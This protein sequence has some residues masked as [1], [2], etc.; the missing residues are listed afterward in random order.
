MAAMH[1]ATLISIVAAARAR[2]PDIVFILADD[3]GYNEMGFMNSTRGLI[4]PH[5]DGLAAGGIVLRN[6]YVQPICSPT[7]SALMTGRYTVRLGTQSSVIYWDTP[8]GIAL[9]ETF[10]PQN[11]KDAGYI[12]GMFGKWHLGMYTEAYTPA[13]RGFDEHMGYY[14][15]CESH[16]T[17]VAA[18]CGAGSPDHDQNYTCRSNAY[19]GYD[20]FKTGPMPNSGTSKPDLSVNHTNSAYLIRDAAVDF[21]HRAAKQEKP[22]FLYLPFQ[23][24]HGPYTC[25]KKYRDQYTSQGAKFTDGE[26]TMFGYITEMDTAVGTVIAALK[27]SGRYENSIIIFSSDNGAPPA[28]ADVN[29]QHGANPGWIARNYPFRGHK[30][31]IWEGGTRVAG[32]VHSPL[33][34]AKVQGTE[35]HEMFHI[36]D[37]LPTIVS[38]GKGSTA[39]NLPLDGH[40]IWPALR[41]GGSSPRT[42]FLYNVNPL[43]KGGQAG[44]PKAG[45]RIGDFKVLAWCYSV[46]GIDGAKETGPISAPHGAKG[47][48]PEFE[49][50]PVLYNLVQ[51]PGETTNIAH[52]PENA[53][54]LKHML[55][56]LKQLADESVEPM[57]W[58][59]PYQ[60]PHYECANCSRHPASKGVGMPWVPW[61]PAQSSQSRSKLSF[62]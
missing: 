51:D 24:I 48:D 33:L 39:R 55:A 50:G 62:V 8:W 17:H 60:G 16:Y 61:Y 54:R 34:P 11:L 36:T 38:L 31:L 59:K 2:T 29:H 4:T 56:R 22:F 47:H 53:Q 13:H 18:C 9:N 41:T 52:N 26:Q 20:W 43:C 3:L 23:N 37:W 25:D 19:T 15:G 35:T 6:Y 44:S 27:A 10:I 45:L 40:N 12:T 28:S 46:K 21:I 30:A 5:L 14:Q 58:V 1:Y 57:Q 49:K 7:R 32:F 42:E